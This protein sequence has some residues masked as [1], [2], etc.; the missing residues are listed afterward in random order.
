MNDEISV[1]DAAM[2]AKE[3]SKELQAAI[4]KAT[5]TGSKTFKTVIGNAI[6]GE[7]A[8]KLKEKCAELPDIVAQVAHIDA[9]WRGK[10]ESPFY[11]RETPVHYPT[12]A[13]EEI[14]NLLRR[15][16]LATDAWVFM[17][18]PRNR[19]ADAAAMLTELGCEIPEEIIWSKTIRG[20][21]IRFGKGRLVRHTHEILLVARRG[22]GRRY[23]GPCLFGS[24]PAVA[25]KEG[26]RHC[27][28]TGPD[29]SGRAR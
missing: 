10:R 24:C 12:M 1:A 19:R 9:P 25:G 5:R 6:M 21:K 17:W 29:R 27:E 22:K 15:L 18:A 3:V 16:K 28:P 2:I 4:Y 23:A 11:A 8:R 20:K 26:A 13:N 7:R 14:A